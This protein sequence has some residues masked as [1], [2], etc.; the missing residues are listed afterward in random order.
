[1]S[2]DP[3]R[4][5]EHL[6][7]PYIDRALTEKEVATVDLHLRECA[8]CNDRYVFERNLRDTVKTSCCQDP[9]P[10]GFVDRLRLRCSGHEA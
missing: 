7:Q 6:L 8:Y 3:C 9:T 5:F 4:G 2:A 1:M 10:E